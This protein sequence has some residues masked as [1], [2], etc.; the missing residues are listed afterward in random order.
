MV[1]KS[2]H[3]QGVAFLLVK[4]VVK[5]TEGDHT[6][7]GNYRRL[8]LGVVISHLFENAILLKIGHLL[9]TDNLQFGYKK[10]HSCAN[11]IYALR[12]CVVYFRDR[13]SMVYTAFLDCSKGFD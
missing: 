13:G 5:D 4:I 6:D 12:S 3:S 11:A 7:P 9:T 10:K 8:T 2:Y 1:N